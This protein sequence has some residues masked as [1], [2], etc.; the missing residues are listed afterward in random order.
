MGKG[1]SSKQKGNGKTC[2]IPKSGGMSYEQFIAQTDNMERSR[3]A[4]HKANQEKGTK[5]K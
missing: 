3:K 2:F 4:D 5:K 1:K